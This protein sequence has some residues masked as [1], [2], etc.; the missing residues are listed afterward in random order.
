[1][2]KAV[3]LFLTLMIGLSC[4]ACG[5]APTS[6][7]QSS[8]P[9]PSSSANTDS[10]SS[11]SSHEETQK[12]EPTQLALN[13]PYSVPDLADLTLLRITTT[14]KVQPT[15]G[16]THYENS[17]DGETYVDM[18]FDVTYNGSSSIDCDE[19]MTLVALNADSATYQST[20]YAVETDN[21]TD[22]SA[23]EPI[24][25]LST[26][27]FHAAVSVP[28][29]ETDITLNLQVGDQLFTYAYNMATPVK[30]VSDLKQGETLGDEEYAT[31]TFDGYEFTDA[32]YPSNTSGYYRYYKVDNSDNTYLAL[33]FT[34][35]NYQSTSQDIDT[36]LS[37]TATFSEKYTYTGFV[38]S[39][40]PDGSS[41]STYN[42]IAP[43]ESAK[44][45]VL[46]EVPKN[47]TDK[48]LS[49]S[50]MFDKEEYVLSKG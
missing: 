14:D 34:L 49:I 31:L 28:K 9:S 38:V 44:V 1:M 6:D 32:V 2:K 42:S 21:M 25:P 19:L 46:I 23:Y 22:I 40:D 24:A 4:T 47:V 29:T 36:F 8:S 26:V 7:S 17:N 48:P 15:M 39:E 33:S 20:L 11:P 5:Q 50:V 27:R 45:F 13:T 16:G 10:Q 12:P 41:L 35:T 30:T 3:S 18:V 37:A 43:L